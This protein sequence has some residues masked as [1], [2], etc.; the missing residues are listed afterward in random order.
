MKNL[1]SLGREL[2][3]TELSADDVAKALRQAADD[4]EQELRK[5]SAAADA[6]GTALGADFV[7]AAAKAGTSVD[8]IRRAAPQPRRVVR[9]HRGER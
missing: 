3:K 8:D 7:N 2:G 5:I 9:R 1:L 6:M 4:A